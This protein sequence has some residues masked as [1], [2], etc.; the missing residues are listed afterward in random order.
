LEICQ[1]DNIFKTGA[2]FSAFLRMCLKKRFY[3]Y[4]LRKGEE[5]N[6]LHKMISE[7]WPDSEHTCRLSPQKAKAGGS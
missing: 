6:R 5:K 4:N 1:N 7:S 3:D 2:Q